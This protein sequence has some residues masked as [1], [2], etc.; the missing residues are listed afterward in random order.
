M[1]VIKSSRFWLALAIIVGAVVL[2]VVGR[3]SGTEALTVGSA[4]LAGFGVGKA[5]G[6][7]PTTV[8]VLVGALGLA[9]CGTTVQANLERAH[10]GVV[11]ADKIA[12]D[13][14]GRQCMDEAQ[15][16]KA[17]ATGK[18]CHAWLACDAKRQ[19]YVAAANALDS[20]LAAVNRLVVDLGIGG[21]K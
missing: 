8:L 14:L 19:R 15:K 20:S 17:A 5:T 12:L 3:V 11:A 7:P 18:D 16:C 10:L 21:A 6:S 4:L 13:V 1:D 2:A 9:G